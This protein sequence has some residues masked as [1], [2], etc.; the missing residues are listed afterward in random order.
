MSCT[1]LRRPDRYVVEVVPSA[2]H[3]SDSK[4]EFGYLKW[5]YIHAK[6]ARFH[7]R[8][9]FDP[10]LTES[11]WT[12]GQYLLT[13][14]EGL[15]TIIVQNGLFAKS[16]AGALSACGFPTCSIHGEKSDNA[17][18]EAFQAFQSDRLPIL[19]IEESLS[20]M[21][22]GL[23]T[24]QVHSVI[25][26][27]TTAGRHR[28][29]YSNTA[30]CFLD[31][32]FTFDRRVRAANAIYCCYRRHQLAKKAEERRQ[33]AKLAGGRRAYSLIN[34]V[35]RV[36]W[37]HYYQYYIGC[38]S[39]LLARVNNGVC[40]TDYDR[41]NK[42]AA[43]L[44]RHLVKLKQ[45]A[46]KNGWDTVDGHTS[47]SVEKV[48]KYWSD[49]AQNVTKWR[50]YLHG[51]EQQKK[52][53]RQL[54]QQAKEK[55]RTEAATTIFCWWRRRQL[56]N[57]FKKMKEESTAATTVFC[58]W[59]RM[60]FQGYIE[61]HRAARIIQCWN[62]QCMFRI[63]CKKSHTA[64]TI[65]CW[66]QS[67]IKR[68]RQLKLDAAASS[69]A[70]RDRGQPLPPI[71]HRQRYRRNQRARRQRNS[72]RSR[73]SHKRGQPRGRP[74]NS[75]QPQQSQQQSIKRRENV[76]GIALSN[77]GRSSIR[78]SVI[79]S[80]HNNSSE[81]NTAG[82]Y[83]LG[84]DL[85][86][87][88]SNG[89]VTALG[90]ALQ[91]SELNSKESVIG[92]TLQDNES[93]SR[94]N[95]AE[96]PQQDSSESHRSSTQPIS[97]LNSKPS[98]RRRHRRRRRKHPCTNHH[99]K[100]EASTSKRHT[101]THPSNIAHLSNISDFCDGI[102]RQLQQASSSDRNL[103]KFVCQL[104]LQT[105]DNQPTEPSIIDKIEPTSTPPSVSNKPSSTINNEFFS[106]IKI[107]D[108]HT[109][110]STITTKLTELPCSVSI[111]TEETTTRPEKP[112]TYLQAL[113]GTTSN[114]G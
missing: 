74:P 69:S 107:V 85:R 31:N 12:L 63:R 21:L 28:I 111:T 6:K 22:L 25:F 57:Y 7:Y 112:S 51:L 73:P 3:G 59:R 26:Y 75:T 98:R 20:Y 11:N 35:H 5:S 68:R 41:K 1:Y 45:V 17:N 101:P 93:S 39:R 18:D 79:G 42:D 77:S 99:Q 100:D 70:L 15:I 110:K 55:R 37:T 62:R 80:V 27:G 16:V 84:K 72:K 54:E 47:I 38:Y 29:S 97:S 104:V 61:Q 36:Q 105:I 8:D 106:S 95:T 34:R 58:W 33:L 13:I 71:N 52:E 19:V 87:R 30:D 113:V 78:G 109:P 102:R 10:T 53:Q 89:R 67:I 40:H 91:S 114:F 90:T 49:L 76:L 65:Q 94:G 82:P 81:M 108:S 44:N 56:D 103:L 92:K 48:Q 86:R 23:D 88:D 2:E 43:R 24:P 32:I 64:T 83:V 50:K 96:K 66:H 9:V 14:Q 60:Q 46:T 4:H